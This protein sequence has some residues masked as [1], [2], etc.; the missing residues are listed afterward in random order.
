M[1]LR[2]R[3]TKLEAR[4]V[5]PP[6]VERD[7]DEFDWSR[8]PADD[9]EW[10]RAIE[11]RTTTAEGRADY[12]SLTL[13]EMTRLEWLAVRASLSHGIQNHSESCRCY[14]CTPYEPRVRYL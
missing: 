12:S 14:Y 9:L 6:T 4:K 11:K 8:T 1:K 7:V 2:N 5:Q 10:V 3:L 13:D